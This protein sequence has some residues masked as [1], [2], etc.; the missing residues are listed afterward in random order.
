MRRVFLGLLLVL[1]TLVVTG[2][3]SKGEISLSE[4]ND[5]LNSTDPAD[6]E[7]AA[8]SFIRSIKTEV[9]ARSQLVRAWTKVGA[10]KMNEADKITVGREDQ[11]KLNLEGGIAKRLG[12]LQSE[13][14]L[15]TEAVSNLQKAAHAL[16]TDKMTW[17]YL[18]LCWGQLSRGQPDDARS[19]ELLEKSDTAY[20]KA[21]KIDPDFKN[22]LYGRGIVL[23]LKKDPD[24]AERVLQRLVALEPKEARGYFALGRVY[25]DRK[26][27]QK[28]QNIYH[29]LREIVPENS[30]KRKSIEENIRKLDMMPKVRP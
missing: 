14:E 11:M 18:G 9:E 28:S 4:G 10:R 2:C 25:Y 30:P 21:I 15:Y 16:P 6:W 22:A 8:D 7:R 20:K 17:Y 29:M 23:V 19:N 5:L 27:Y 13:Y 24:E 12:M 26:E 1:V 3:S